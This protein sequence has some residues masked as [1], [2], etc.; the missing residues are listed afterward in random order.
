MRRMLVLTLALASIVSMAA[1]AD[2]RGENS[3]G[4]DEGRHH[5]GGKHHERGKHHEPGKILAFQTMYAVDGPFLGEANAIRDVV[6][7][8]AAWVLRSARGS[9]DTTGHL[10]IQVRGLIFA[11]GS[12]NDEDTF[13]GLVSCLTENGPTVEPASVT[14]QGFPAT[15]TGDSVI[16]AHV[17]LPNPCVAPIVFVLAGSEDKWFAVTGFESE[18]EEAN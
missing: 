12:P 15:P 7:D 16:D 11:D 14:T 5:E 3:Q 6:G 9:L 18:E 4:S 2:S 13:R 10:R 8:E 1:W 17:E